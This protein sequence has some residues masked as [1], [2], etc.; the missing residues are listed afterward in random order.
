MTI[1]YT[2]TYE[3]TESQLRKVVDLMAT[4]SDPPLTMDEV[5]GNDY[6]KEYLCE[7]IIMCGYDIEDFFICDGW[8]DWRDYR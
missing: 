5:L 3:I 8:C 1:V 4:E 7:G 6:L 2:Q